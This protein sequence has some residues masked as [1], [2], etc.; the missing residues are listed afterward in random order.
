MW[1]IF[2]LLALL[3]FGFKNFFEK[4][5]V[6]KGDIEAVMMVERLTAFLIISSSFLFYVTRSGESILVFR[7][8]NS[9]MIKIRTSTF[10][11]S[12]SNLSMPLTYVRCEQLKSSHN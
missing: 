1:L 8:N 11:I 10:F 6:E 5:S 7:I 9:I 4:L 2:A 12:L 3:L